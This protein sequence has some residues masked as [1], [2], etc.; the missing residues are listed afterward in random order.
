M[1]HTLHLLILNKYS[2]E[3]MSDSPGSSAM[4]LDFQD[5]SKEPAESQQNNNPDV[6]VAPPASTN[7]VH[8]QLIA[9]GFIFTPVYVQANTSRVYTENFFTMWSKP[10]AK[11]SARPLR[12]AVC[13]CTHGKC[14]M[15]GNVLHLFCIANY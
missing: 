13:K 12:W 2:P 4:S 7:P 5:D 8:Q 6:D 10:N 14:S 9:E 1:P 15:C 3:V 11:D